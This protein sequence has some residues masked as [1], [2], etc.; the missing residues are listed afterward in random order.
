MTVRVIVVGA[1]IAGLTAAVALHR[2][3]HDVTV[4]ER[5]PDPRVESSD[6]RAESRGG[7]SI[8]PNALAALDRIDVGE[9]VRAAG[10]A[11][12]AGAVRWRDGSWIRRPAADRL[13][14]ALGEP[15]IVIERSV[16]RAVLAER[17]PVGT[18]R[19]GVDVTSSS[20]LDA[21]LVIGADGIASRVAVEL[22]GPLPR[23]YCGYTAWRGVADA[24]FD[25]VLAGE[26]LGPR[27]QFGL[28]PLGEDR[29]YWFA[30]Q[31][32]REK[33]FFD[34]ELAHVKD[35]V[36]GW[37]APL[38]ELVSATAPRNLLRNDLHDRPIARRW[39][40][41]RS[42]LIGDAA[43]PMRPH[44]GQGGCQAIEDAV[45]LAA[46]IAAGPHVASACRTFESVRRGRVTAIVRESKLIG[47]I[48]NGRPAVLTGAV[49]RA[50]VLGPDL[51]VRTH[52]AQIAGKSAFERN[53]DRI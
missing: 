9:A 4:L 6:P 15:L 40:D 19:Y 52:L 50:S 45:I 17:L 43:H 30:T 26:V 47:R 11:V 14:D 29:T 49:I 22:N 39:S 36:T 34:D 48:V 28:V 10:G 7:I 42:V 16:L 8:W 35:L 32:L 53:L 31:Q 12:A 5:V 3:G 33:S 2:D 13:I 44:L 38:P 37:A 24:S 20:E 25:P 1:G 51:L 18:V 23:T 27:S 21:D 41:G 46:C